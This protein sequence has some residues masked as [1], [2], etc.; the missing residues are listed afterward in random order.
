M[1]EFLLLLLSLTLSGSALSLL[2]LLVRRLAGGRLP[3]AFC[4]YAWLLVVIRLAI[5]FGFGLSLPALPQGADSRTAQIQAE[6]PAEPTGGQSITTPAAPTAGQTPDTFLTGEV[7]SLQAH[8]ALSLWDVLFLLWLLGALGLLIWHMAAYAWFGHRVRRSLTPPP[9]EASALFEQLGK[10]RRVRL[11]SSDQ[12]DTPMLLGLLRPVI[13]LPRNGPALRY[14]DLSAALRHE[15]T[16]CKRG[17]ILY[18]WLVVLVTALHWFNPLVHWLG[19]R[20]ALDC[21]LSCD[22]AVLSALPPEDRMG[23]GEML[24]ALAARHRLPAGVTAT[25]LCEE[26]RQLKAR[27]QGILGYRKPTRAVL[28]GALALGL[29]LACCACGVLDLTAQ[30]ETPS[31]PATPEPEGAGSDPYGA[32]LDRYEEALSLRQPEDYPDLPVILTNPYWAWTD[33]DSLL[34]RTGYARADLDGDGSEELLLGWVGN[35]I[36]NLDQ[37]YVF[38]IYTLVDGQPVLAVEGWERNTYVLGADGYLYNCGSSGADRTQ[39]NKYRFD[40]AAEGYL[41]TVEHISVP[42]NGQEAVEAGEGWM[43][44]GVSIPCTAFAS[45]ETVYQDVLLGN[46]SFLYWA[47]GAEE[48]VSRMVAEVPALFSPY[49]D[50]AQIGQFAVLDLDGDGTTEVVLW[51]TDVANDMGGYLV[52]HQEGGRI[53][54]YPSHWRTFWNLKTDGTFEY[55]YPAG[56]EGGAASVRF[57]GAGMELDKRICGQGRQFE[58]TTFLVDGRPVSEAEY[59]AAWDAQDQKPDAVWYPWNEDNIRAFT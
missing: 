52:L 32:L 59:N 48:P 22:E 57:T 12:V 50:Y 40:P 51:V 26:K 44:S 58:F 21:E 2:L 28:C 41:E 11:A 15:L 24:L 56:N 55:S 1:R 18:K 19:R 34:P 39:W 14:K 7:P 37:G 16:H 38:A 47:E 25:T 33:T 9:A 10:V 31:A 53:Y 35:D 49:S 4:Y 30:A 43:A 27:L 6:D 13:V 54:G 3:R 36:W 42:E 20:I 29:V 45:P 5:P 23:Y 46:A 17:D 8:P